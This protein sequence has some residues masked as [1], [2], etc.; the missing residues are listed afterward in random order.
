MTQP[1][2]HWDEAPARHYC[3]GPMGAMWQDLGRVSGSVNVGVRR[4][5]VDAG[6]QSTPVHVHDAEEEIFYILGGGDHILDY[7]HRDWDAGTH[8][9]QSV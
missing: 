8:S 9:V 4:M 3:L 5:Q 6:K 7:A 2:A 1:L